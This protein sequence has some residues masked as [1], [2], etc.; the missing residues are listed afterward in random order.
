VKKQI[1]MN[2]DLLNILSNSNKDID[3]QQL[4]DYLS[5]NLS[6]EPLHEVERSMADNAFLNDAVEGLQDIG[7]KKNLQAYVEELNAALHKSVAKKKQRRLKRRL[8][9]NP[10]AYLAILLVITFCILAYVLIRKTL[11][12]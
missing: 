2:K 3:N 6:G 12:H 8:K 10:W 7:N 5:G 4:M 1:D 9:E 11:P